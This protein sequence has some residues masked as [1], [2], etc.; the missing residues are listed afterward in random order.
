MAIRY[1]T[2]EAPNLDPLIIRRNN[3]PRENETGFNHILPVVNSNGSFLFKG[4]IETIRVTFKKPEEPPKNEVKNV[5]IREFIGS[6]QNVS[7]S[8]ENGLSREVV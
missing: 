6:T 5:T 3:K 4:E 1:Q 8:V 2:V 7:P